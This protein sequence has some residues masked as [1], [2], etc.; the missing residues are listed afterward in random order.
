MLDEPL[1]LEADGAEEPR[2]GHTGFRSRTDLLNTLASS[3][4]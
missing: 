3:S 1:D 2:L 4:R